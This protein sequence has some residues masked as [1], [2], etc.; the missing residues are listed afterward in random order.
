MIHVMSKGGRRVWLLIPVNSTQNSGITRYVR[1]GDESDS[2]K[3]HLEGRSGASGYFVF[4]LEQKFDCIA[5]WS[6]Q[7]CSTDQKPGHQHRSRR[8]KSMPL[9]GNAYDVYVASGDLT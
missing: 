8:R 4:P 5:H 1:S 6:F 9:G 3:V 7:Y 2:P